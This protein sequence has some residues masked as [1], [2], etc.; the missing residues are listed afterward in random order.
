MSANDAITLLVEGKM[1]PGVNFVEG[2]TAAFETFAKWYQ[3]DEFGRI[4]PMNLGLVKEY[5][6]MVQS[7]AMQEQQQQML[8]QAAQQFQAMM[9]N[10]GQGAAPPMGGEA[11]EMQTEAPTQAEIAG[12]GTQGQGPGGA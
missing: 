11:P 7:A 5:L 6:Q 1:P 8:A 10:R 2:A 4:A 9:G 3:S 12:G